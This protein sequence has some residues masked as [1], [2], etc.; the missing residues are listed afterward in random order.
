[1]AY[2]RDVSDTRESPALDIIGLLDQKGSKVSY[3]DPLVP[4][5]DL[6]GKSYESTPLDSVLLGRHDCVVIVADHTQFDWEYIAKHSRLVFDT[7]NA[8]VGIRNRHSNI[9]VL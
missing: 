2:K 3:H 1:M 8:T 9:A 6:S 5:L 4:V 7:R